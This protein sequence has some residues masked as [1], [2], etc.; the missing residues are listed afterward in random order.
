MEIL[1]TII[2]FV[3]LVG[4]IAAP[5]LILVRFNR[6]NVRYKFVVFLIPALIITL[7]LTFLFAWWSHTSNQILL[8]H[9]GYDFG[10]MSDAERFTNV[11]RE[12]IERVKKV[13]MSMMGV[14]WPLRAF[15]TYVMYLPYLLV[16]YLISFFILKYR[17]GH[18]AKR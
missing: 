3:L 1:A 16:V 14:G 17:H 6:L 2:S 4:I 12:N 10:A 15:M 11:S 5:L 18:M 7:I 13:Q 9:Y 8:S